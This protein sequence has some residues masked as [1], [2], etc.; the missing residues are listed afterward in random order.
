MLTWIEKKAMSTVKTHNFY[1]ANESFSGFIG[2]LP[3]ENDRP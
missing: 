1:A 2:N 3:V